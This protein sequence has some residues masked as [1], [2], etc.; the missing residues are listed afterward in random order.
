MKFDREKLRASIRLSI[1][2]AKGVSRK[3]KVILITG[4]GIAAIGG[5]DPEIASCLIELFL[6]E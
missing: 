6:S 3:K 2:K 4:V 1:Q 5:I